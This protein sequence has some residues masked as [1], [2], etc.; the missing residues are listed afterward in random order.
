MRFLA[1]PI[2]SLLAFLP[3]PQ[4]QQKGEVPEF[5][6][7]VPAAQPEPV[8]AILPPVLPALEPPQKPADPLAGMKAAPNPTVAA[9]AALA[10]AKGLDDA[11][12][13]YVR[14]LWVPGGAADSDLWRTVVFALNTISRSPIPYR[15]V[16][17]AK[18]ELI[19]LDLRALGPVASDLTSYLE[20][21]EFLQNDPHFSLLVTK[22][23]LAALAGLG[24]DQEVQIKVT[25]DISK[26]VPPFQHEGR[27][28]TTKWTT[29]TVL[30]SVPVAEAVKKVA[31]VRLDPVHVP[32]LVELQQVC[33]SRAPIVHYAYFATRSLGTVK[34]DGL[35]KE[36]WGGLYYD[37]AG[38]ADTQ[39]GLLEAVG[40]GNVKAGIT[41][42][43]I[44][45]K[46]RSD[47]RVAIFRSDVTGQPRRV[48]WFLIP[49]GRNGPAWA[50]ITNDVAQKDIDLS[51]HPILNLDKVKDRGRE[52]I[53]GKP[54]GFQGFSINNAEGKRLDAVPQ[55]IAND[56][57]VPTP[58]PPILHG[59][60]AC[61][62]CHGVHDGYQPLRNDALAILR[63]FDAFGDVGRENLNRE[64]TDT[65]NRIAGWYAG[66][67]DRVLRMA[68]DEYAAAVLRATGPWKSSVDQVDIVRLASGKIGEVYNRYVYDLVTPRQA[69]LEL[70]FE[71]TEA[72][73]VATLKLLLPPAVGYGGP[74]SII[75]EDPRLA[76]LLSGLS[77]NR[78]DWS[79]VYSFAAARV[80]Q[81]LQR[82]GG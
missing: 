47:Q 71:V 19:R 74:S 52:I 59:A 69:L 16:V 14:Y 32:A 65:V 6:E 4:P 5:R 29:R 54:N 80:Q 50:F 64:V 17:L 36:L 70:G 73:A 43:E 58:H 18:G 81:S 11:S 39:D 7:P 62:R 3:G 44:F 51:Q 78:T 82:N 53:F 61:I 27:T 41:A 26:T 13:F 75:P 42:T 79:L 21:W 67:P 76:A 33:Q 60:I 48:E 49:S 31:L 1:I 34:E 57:T 30:K 46:L 66:S 23:M 8:A 9:A 77:I 10:D 15:P 72:D 68:R 20:Q 56:R 40:V 35:Y 24:V 45:A 2:L 38:I 25:E 28:L 63:H 55:D 12:R 22:D 37:L